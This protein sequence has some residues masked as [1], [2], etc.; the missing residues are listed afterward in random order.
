MTKNHGT[1]RNG[2][3]RRSDCQKPEVRPEPEHVEAKRVG[4]KPFLK[5]ETDDRQDHARDHVGLTL[6]DVLIERT[7]GRMTSTWD[8]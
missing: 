4:W 7:L 8:T 5:G 6:E 1:R 2:G 3:P